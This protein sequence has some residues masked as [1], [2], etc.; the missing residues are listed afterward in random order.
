MVIIERSSVATD[1]QYTV[2]VSAG[3][4]RWRPA[5]GQMAMAQH[6]GAPSLSWMLRLV[7]NVMALSTILLLVWSQLRASAK[8][9]V[10]GWSRCFGGSVTEVYRACRKPKIHLVVALYPFSSS[11]SAS[12]HS[13]HFHSSAGLVLLRSMLTHASLL[14]TALFTCRPTPTASEASDL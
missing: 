12:I 9:V 6:V 1:A 8:L 2:Q 3:A 7:V 11:A 10:T 4:A 5:A 13:V 14:W